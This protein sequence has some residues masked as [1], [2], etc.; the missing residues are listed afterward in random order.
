[1]CVCGPPPPVFMKPGDIASPLLDD[2]IGSHWGSS[3]R[4]LLTPPDTHAKAQA[5]F[6]GCDS[7]YLISSFSSLWALLACL[8]AIGAGLAFA[9]RRATAFC[10]LG[11]GIL[12]SAVDTGLR[13]LQ[14]LDMPAA[15]RETMIGNLPSQILANALFQFA[16]P[17]AVGWAVAQLMGGRKTGPDAKADNPAI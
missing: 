5:F 4:A 6:C 16:I 8:L 3:I 2:W 1:M 7:G 15:F 11:A 9:S 17:F 14:L 10:M 13:L 12:I